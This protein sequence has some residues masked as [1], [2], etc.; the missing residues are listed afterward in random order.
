MKICLSCEGV[1]N[2]Q[3]SRCGHCGAF[4]LPTDAVHY[5]MRRGEVDAGNPLI[6]TVIDGKYRLQ[7]VLGRGGLGT[8]FRAQHI[9]SLMAVALKLLHPRFAER[10]EYRRALLPEARR[11]ATVVHERCARLLDAGETE[12]GIAYLAMELVAGETLDVLVRRGRLPPSLGV[13]ILAQVAQALGAIHAVGL[14]HCDLSP[15]NVMVAAR[16]DG[17]R[18]K[19]LDFGIAR[20][21]SLADPHRQQDDL[22]GFV[23]PAFSAPELLAGGAVDARADLWSFGALAWLLLTG[24]M[25]VEDGHG[26][27]SAAAGSRPW[28]AGVRVPRR[29]KRLVHRC[30][31]TDPASRPASAAV[32][33]RELAIVR[34]A[35]RPAV[36]RA[37]LGVFA[38]GVV[39][40]LASGGETS[41]PFLQPLSGS[42]LEWVPGPLPH[43][44][45][46]SVLASRCL[47][48]LGFG[49][50]GLQPDRLRA[51][52]V[53][54]GQVLSHTWLRPEPGVA[55]G[56]LLLSTA[57]LEWRQV[58]Q[59]LQ[60]ASADGPIDLVFVV[61]GGPPLGSTRLRLD[62]SPPSLGASLAG[63]PD[64]R[65]A[66][67]LL[68]QARDDIGL[69][70]IT[71]QCRLEDG[72]SW[73]LPVPPAEGAIDLGTLLGDLVA[74]PD[75]LGGGELVVRA[76][77]LAGNDA[78]LAPIRFASCDVRA[79]AVIEASGPLGEP[80]VPTAAGVVRL[81][82]RTSFPEAGCRLRVSCADGP[83]RELRLADAGTLHVVEFSAGS[84]AVRDGIWRFQVVDSRGNAT[85][86]ELPVSVRDRSTRIEFQAEG[87]VARMVGDEL[88]IADRPVAVTA[89][90]GRNWTVG[91]VRIE[92]SPAAIAVAGASVVPFAVEA[93]GVVRL[94]LPALAA[95]PHLLRFTLEELVGGRDR[96]VSTSVSVRLR[97]LPAIV[98]VRVP[99]PSS[100]FLPGLLQA[101][102]LQPRGG[103]F[104][105]GSGW[106]FDPALRPYVRG[107]LWVHDGEA[108]PRLVEPAAPGEPLLPTFVPIAGH[109]RLALELLDALDR[110]VQVAAGGD[111]APAQASAGPMRI[112]DFWWHDQP[113]SLI[114]EELLLEFGQQARIE[115]RFPVP[116]SAADAGELRLGILQSE[117]AASSV[118]P[119]GTTSRVRFDV[120]FLVW[121]VAA[122]LADA[123]RDD[124][125]AQLERRL[126]AYVATPIGRTELSVRLR[127]VRSTLRPL[128]LAEL[129]AADGPFLP[130]ALAAL[131]LLPVLAPAGPFAEPVP[132]GAPPRAAFRPQP[133]VAVRNLADF[134]L[135]D[136]EFSRNQAE[137]LAALVPR[138]DA[139]SRARCVHA[140][141]PLGA[142]RL[143]LENLLPAAAAGL[144][145]DAALTGVTF[146]QA[147]ALCR[148]LGVAVVGDPDAF[149]LP[150]GC[151]L[152]LAAFGATMPTSCHGAG[153]NGGRVSLA[154]FLAT[155]D[156]GAAAG[157]RAA[158][159]LGDVVPTAFGESFYG[160]DF[161]A[162]EWVLD[163]PHVAGAELLLAE[164]ASDH[165]THLAR[166]MELAAGNLV[167]MPVAGELLLRLGVVRGLPTGL[168]SGLLDAT[169]RP[170][171]VHA[172]DAMPGSVPGVLRTEQVRR[173]GRDLLADGV[174]SRLSSVGFRVAGE[175]E[176]LPARGAR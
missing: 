124:F 66:S 171:S 74:S 136:R 157:A 131:R 120:P 167:S 19:V 67:R 29:L 165:R 16:D 117:I 1:T 156:A 69:R 68:V 87:N 15:R 172:A 170:L 63:G 93:P 154:V 12:D 98:Q 155:G 51:D 20:S 11:A 145:P 109:N 115:L 114:G 53:R 78:V 9:G 94:Q 119:Q 35:R 140:G 159:A 85:A 161:G 84:E 21:V 163:L 91:E 42:Q 166:A 71:V 56:T 150:L 17:L 5:P 102:L 73:E 26:E 6:G 113:P 64:L 105:D 33:G 82:V 169:G 8:V 34:G 173:D 4:L 139:G 36:V 125:A 107:R 46:V 162:R 97:V 48:T 133:A 70:A 47:D 24:S 32:V 110:P 37:A 38:A 3:A 86:S 175:P 152:E 27:S 89:T 81:R 72:R 7:G 118:V 2:A 122:N 52:L 121:R 168:R 144:P 43:A 128:S 57:Q 59:G 141:D 135:Q 160:L 106:G 22:A 49:F 31:A 76:V 30:L 149:R 108:V 143:L 123:T 158:M 54:D 40:T 83:V 127:L 62:D 75:E 14:V 134:L 80:F 50:G 65:A 176:R 44:H 95:G 138:L 88:V 164:W 104:V 148:L 132:D 146:H 153:A 129:A 147:W 23:N 39:A 28:P 130:D 103:G 41:L 112:A 45:P 13:D 137:A 60:R 90:L 142:A 99:T 58:V 126:E 101:R 18:V 61:P 25:P 55:A 10:S 96:G 79:P 174:D 92:P 116:F 151:E 111:E 100:R 77:D